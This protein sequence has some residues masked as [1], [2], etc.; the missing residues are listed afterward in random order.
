MR[1]KNQIVDDFVVGTLKNKNIRIASIDLVLSLLSGGF[2][3]KIQKNSVLG[4]AR[5][6]GFEVP[7]LKIKGNRWQSLSLGR[8]Y[9][10]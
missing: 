5:I 7:V 10:A 8:A 9:T 2:I 3:K 1:F 6:Q 4:V